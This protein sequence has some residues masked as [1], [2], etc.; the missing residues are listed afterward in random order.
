MKKLQSNRTPEARAGSSEDE[1]DSDASSDVAAAAT[2]TV[3]DVSDDVGFQRAKEFLD[4]LEKGSRR[5]SYRQTLRKLVSAGVSEAVEKQKVSPSF[6]P[7][8]LC[9]IFFTRAK[10]LA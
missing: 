2:S 9:V 7:H 6:F 5:A 4:I 3:V 1:S 8:L 10:H